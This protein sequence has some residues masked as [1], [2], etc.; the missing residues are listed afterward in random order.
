MSVSTEVD[1]KSRGTGHGQ[2]IISC[3]TE[4]AQQVHPACGLYEWFKHMR[5]TIFWRVIIAQ[6]LL[7]A[8]VLTL[9]LYALDRLNWLNQLNASILTTDAAC[10]QEEKRLLKSFLSELRNAEKYLLLKD[11]AFYDAYIQGRKDFTETLDRIGLFIDTPEERDLAE[12]I[13]R[14]HGSLRLETEATPDDSYS[15]YVKDE[16]SNAIIERTNELIR[17]REQIMG[18]RTAEARDQAASAAGVM[19]WLILGGIS[20]ALL[21]AY[22]HAR[23]VSRPLKRLSWEMH[24]VGKGEVGHPV[25]LRAPQEVHDLSQTFNWMTEKLAEFDN[26]K[27]DFTAHVSHELRTPLTA[28]REGTAILLEGIPGPLTA[29]QREILE[30]VRNHSERLFHSISS[31]LDLSKM[32]AQMMEYEF[33]ACDLRALIGRSIETVQLIARSKNIELEKKLTEPLPLLFL[34]ERRMQQVFDNLLNNAL[35]F[36][37]EGGRIFITAG[38]VNRADERGDMVEVR[39]SDTGD[40][41]EEED[42]ER[43]FTRFYQ[44]SHSGGKRHQGTGLGLAIARYIVE[45]HRGEIHVE[46]VVGSG[47]TFV[48]ALPVNSGIM[49]GVEDPACG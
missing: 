49:S 47:S 10:I 30:V 13:A 32:D 11:S 1:L 21:M 18:N 38:L 8:L 31:I 39:V 48:V 17:V 43:V 23:G 14:L 46:S 22:F 40:G 34:D 26:L 20:G 29:P 41:I 24:R 27:A 2:T 15:K 33:M 19:A 9:G 35:K 44:S 4:D 7:I 28:I 5:L 3:S 6:S 36:T 25:E 42:L 16:L 45:A 37:P 12:Q